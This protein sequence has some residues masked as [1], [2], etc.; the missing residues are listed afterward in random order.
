[1]CVESSSSPKENRENNGNNDDVQEE[2]NMYCISESSHVGASDMEQQIAVEHPP[3]K[4]YRSSRQSATI[5]T[6][7]LRWKVDRFG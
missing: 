4:L 1:M 3:A 2:K 7:V 5:C 6:H